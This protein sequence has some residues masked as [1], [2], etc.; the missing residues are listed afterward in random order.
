MKYFFDT[1][2]HEGF[3][4]PFKWLPKIGKLNN[5]YWTIQLISIGIVAEDGREYYA[6]SNEFD[7]KWAWNSWQ[8]R[9]GQGDRNNVEP[10]EYWLRENVLYPIWAELRY[11]EYTSEPNEVSQEFLGVFDKMEPNAA[12]DLYKSQLLEYSYKFNEGGYDD[13]KRLLKKY[14]KSKERIAFDVFRFVHRDIISKYDDKIS[15][16]ETIVNSAYAQGKEPHEFYAYYADYDWVVFCTLFGKMINLPTGFPMYC[17]DLKQMLDENV[18]ALNWMYAR[19]IWSNKNRS[20][21]TIGRGEHQEKDRT[22]AFDE[23]LKVLKEL[24]EYPKNDNSHSAIHDARWNRKLF[25]F[26]QKITSE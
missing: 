16:A 22:S 13:L 6:I 12:F 15:F 14:G 20:I 25:D 24:K 8:P 11:K 26:I 7:L 4:K 10:K 23:K 3:R 17:K 19:D 9:K 18:E 5:P 21:E 1:E 2:F